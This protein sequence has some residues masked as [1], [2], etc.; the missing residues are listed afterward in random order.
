MPRLFARRPEAD[1]TAFVFGATCAHE[2]VSTTKKMAENIL[3]ATRIIWFTTMVP[4]SARTSHVKT[5]ERLLKIAKAMRAVA[6]CGK[7]S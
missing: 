3:A 4:D 5:A 2:T 7:K 6:C 1:E